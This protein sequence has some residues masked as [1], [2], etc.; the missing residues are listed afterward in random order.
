MIGKIKKYFKDRRVSGKYNA[1]RPRYAGLLMYCIKP[2]EK[3][4]FSGNNKRP[5]ANDRRRVGI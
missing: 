5:E 2:G 3:L 1:I 4:D